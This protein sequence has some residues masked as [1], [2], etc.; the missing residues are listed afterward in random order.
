MRASARAS[1]LLL[2]FFGCF[3]VDATADDAC[4]FRRR[5]AGARQWR[6]TLGPRR[7]VRGQRRRRDDGTDSD[8]APRVSAR[9]CKRQHH[10]LAQVTMPILVKQK[11]SRN[12]YP[13]AALGAAFE[14]LDAS[15]M[16]GAI[17]LW[18]SATMFGYCYGCIALPSIVA[19]LAI[20]IRLQQQ[21]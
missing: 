15:P 10:G 5:G 1:P 3:V 8:E 18:I 17:W 16:R 21:Q 6:V 12:P 4:G 9:S 19:R 13:V 14:S 7:C 11:L 20:L 2:R